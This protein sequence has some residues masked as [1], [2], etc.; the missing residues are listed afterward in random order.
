MRQIVRRL[1][2]SSEQIG[3]TVRLDIGLGGRVKS[4]MQLGRTRFREQRTPH[5][6]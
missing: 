5:C 3:R 4:S 2:K 6:T 1:S